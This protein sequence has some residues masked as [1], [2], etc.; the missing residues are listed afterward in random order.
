MVRGI[1]TLMA[2]LFILYCS[3]NNVHA[4]ASG[5]FNIF[6]TDAEALGKANAFTAEADNAS[7]VH[8]NPAGTTQLEGTHASF[9]VTL[10]K[11]LVTHTDSSGVETQMRE[12]KFFVPGLFVVS[13]FG[14]DQ[15]R[16]GFG[17]KSNFGSGTEWAT[18]SFS[19]Y[20]ATKSELEN[21]DYL[22]TGAYQVNDRVSI[23]LGLDLVRS[24]ISL[25]KNVNQVNGPDGQVQV[26]G[27]DVGFGY[28]VSTL[29]R[30]NDQH[31]VGIVYNSSVGLTHDGDV[32]L[33]GLN[34]ANPN[35]LQTVFGGTSFSTTAV[36]KLELPQS[37]TLGYTFEPN[38]DWL[39]NFDATW[40]DW[41]SIHRLDFE[42]P[43]VT[44]ATQ[45]QVLNSS[46]SPLDWGS[47]VSFGVGVEYACSESTRV[48]AG[49]G[50]N[51]TPIPQNNFNT[52]LPDADSHNLSAGVGIELTD[53][54]TVDMAYMAIIFEDRTVDN[55]VGNAFGGNIDGEYEKYI[56]T[57]L[58]TVSTSF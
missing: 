11:P 39:V 20:V 38:E 36:G 50:Y 29:I 6:G 51:P 4:A 30:L 33:T 18:D 34:N 12:K 10:L 57:G 15:F 47:T 37:L 49:Y 48:R 42:Y 23:G 54:L 25:N 53:N 3:V 27:T 21:I 56:H 13:D 7:A 31:K 24:K 8:F 43:D 2:L 44:N 52:F 58:I 1:K 26:K 16:F 17:V 14:M 28:N 55:T 41:S 9:G 5:A 32:H 35:F 19:R 45:L 46:D 22:V 40:M